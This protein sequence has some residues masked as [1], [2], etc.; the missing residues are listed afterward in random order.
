M[1]PEWFAEWVVTETDNWHP[2]PNA[3]DW[4]KKEFADWMGEHETKEDGLI[5]D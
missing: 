5:V 1:I 3:P 2:K 4:V